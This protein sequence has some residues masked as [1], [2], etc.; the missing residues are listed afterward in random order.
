MHTIAENTQSDECVC[1]ALTS[2]SGLLVRTD[3][4]ELD[5]LAYVGQLAG[6]AQRVVG[7]AHAAQVE[8]VEHQRRHGQW[9]AT[10]S[11]RGRGEAPTRAIDVRLDDRLE[12]GVQI[13]GVEA[14]LVA[15]RQLL[16]C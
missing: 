4:V 2:A 16:T 13:V 1:A 7:Y 15:A 12:N 3:R 5:E 10:S 8:H 14:L 6:V 9:I 11:D